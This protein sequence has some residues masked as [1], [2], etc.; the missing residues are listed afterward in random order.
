[1]ARGG[2]DIG[3]VHQLHGGGN[4]G[5]RVGGVIQNDAFKHIFGIR[6]GVGL[7][8]SQKEAVPCTETLLGIAAGKRTQEADLHGRLFSMGRGGEGK[9]RKQ[10]P[11]NGGAAAGVEMSHLCPSS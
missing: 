9:G 11:R 10:E 2:G 8:D 1:M 7:L 4:A 5:L 6:V 3:V